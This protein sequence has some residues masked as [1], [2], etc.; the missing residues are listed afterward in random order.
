M[1][2]YTYCVH[3][4]NI[5]LLPVLIGYGLASGVVLKQYGSVSVGGL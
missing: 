3:A 4:C 2:V 1:H 5:G